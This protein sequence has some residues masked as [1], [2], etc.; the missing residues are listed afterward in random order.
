M[1]ARIGQGAEK[2]LT[3]TIT[4]HDYRRMPWK[5]GGGETIE[6]AISPEGASLD[7]F[8]WRVSMARVETDGP[9]S[10]F[11]GVD[12][13]LAILKGGGMRLSISAHLAIEAT[14]VTEPLTFDA[15]ADT[16][17]QL[18]E[19]PVTDLNVMTRRSH[20]SHR[21]TRL[22]LDRSMLVAVAACETLLI[23]WGDGL[24][25]ETE[26]G[27]ATLDPGDALHG[28]GARS[29]WRVATYRPGHAYL[30]EIFSLSNK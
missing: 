24:S 16:E 29:T 21:L 18:L 11:P 13:T 2:G 4:A 17:A 25:V 7:D 9:F 28:R 1:N 30:V 26:A 23:A 12:R 10:K 15:G 6:I 8:D 3:R 19:G 27:A 14:L 5:N 22:A 20:F